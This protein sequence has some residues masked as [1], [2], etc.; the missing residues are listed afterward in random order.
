MDQLVVL[1]PEAIS[2]WIRKG[3]VIDRYFNPGDLFEKVHVVICSDDT[4]DLEALQRL[5]GTASLSLEVWRF[6]R[7]WRVASVALNPMLL[8]VWARKAAQ[9]LLPLEPTLIRCHGPYQNGLV[10]REVKR[11]S[12]TPYVVSL[13]TN[14]DVDLR[15]RP[16]GVVLGLYHKLTRICERQVLKDADLVLPVYESIVPYLS[17]LGIA[18]YKVHYNMINAR[19][20]QPKLNYDLSSP[21]KIVS[22]GRLYSLK[23]PSEIIRSL[24][25]VDKAVL[26]LIGDGPLRIDLQNLAAE[27]GLGERVKFVPHLAN[28]LVIDEVR[29][30]DVFVVHSEHWELSKSVL[31]ALLLGMPIIVN[32]RRGDAT[33]ELASTSVLQVSNSAK[34]YAEAISSLLRD[35]VRRAKLGQQNREAAAILWSARESE[36]RFESTYRELVE[37]RGK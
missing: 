16:A 10:A 18:N 9:K 24:V 26:T 29:S 19:T 34:A 13:H 11:A 28:D 4:P 17:S 7:W 12:R 33:P 22:V 6:P 23:N 14:P 2:E 27:L 25:Q 31:E 36:A 37:A 8:R 5:V 15:S 3:E 21:P 20:S 30:A 35:D 1:M 32:R